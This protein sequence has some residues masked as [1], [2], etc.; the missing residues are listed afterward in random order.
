M[1]SIKVLLCVAGPMLVAWGCAPL[2][3]PGMPAAGLPR[4]ATSTSVPTPVAAPI[5]SEPSP[6]A[7]AVLSTIPEPL[8]RLGSAASADSAGAPS[9]VAPPDTAVLEGDSA[10]PVP[11]PT[12]AL[13][14]EATRSPVVIS[15]PP[16]AAPPDS[17]SRDTCWRVQVAARTVQ[18]RAR[19]L[20]EAA[21]SLLLVEAEVVREGE[22]YKVRLK[23]C[24]SKAAAE[25]MRRRAAASGFQGA[26]RYPVRAR[27]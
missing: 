18:A 11:T 26:F 17:A 7:L 27:P 6:E 9:S 8:A 13:G 2:P 20:A 5:D 23:P 4:P 25:S 3:P 1:S 15:A 16:P 10:V 24:F 22:S 12:K 14:E 19:S 21:T